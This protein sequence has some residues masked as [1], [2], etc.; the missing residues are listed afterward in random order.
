MKKLILSLIVA[1]GIVQYGYAQT[2]NTKMSFSKQPGAATAVQES[3][4]SKENIYLTVDLNGKTVKDFFKL[5][6]V[7]AGS[8]YGYLFYVIEV[9]KG[10]QLIKDNSWNIAYIPEADKKNTT[11]KMDVLPLPAQATTVL[12]ATPQFDAGLAA[13]PLYEL[14]AKRTFRETGTY[15]IRIRI[16]NRTMDVYG[17]EQPDEKW[18]TCSG[19]FTFDFN[20]EDVPALLKNGEA[21]DAAV[22]KKAFKK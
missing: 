14:L 10:N 18:P 5:P 4:S 17:A 13:G 19:S 7:S 20:E 2:E 22:A 16:Y 11:L 8:P 6:D 15:T 1:A 3:F 21:A 9:Y 12:S